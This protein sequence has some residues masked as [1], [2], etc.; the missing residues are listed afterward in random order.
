VA[1]LPFF[2]RG[3]FSAVVGAL[4]VAAAIAAERPP[5]PGT[6]RARLRDEDGALPNLLLITVDTLRADHVES[7]G[8]PFPGLTPSLDQ[9]AATGTVF[10]NTTSPAPAT[11]PGLAGLMTGSYAGRHHVLSNHRRVPVDVRVLAG[12]LKLHGYAT[13]AFVGNH[14]LRREQSGFGR[15]FEH[16][17]PFMPDEGHAS[18]GEGVRRAIAWLDG[19]PREPWLLWLHLMSP[20]GPYNSAPPPPPMVADREDP[21]PDRRLRLSPSNYG[22]GVLPKYQVLREPP[23]AA[24][25]RRRYRE[26]VFFVDAEIGHLLRALEERHLADRTL[27]I[28]ASDHGE[29]LGEH[30]LFFQHGWLPNEASVR[31]PMI[32]RLP[33]RVAEGHRVRAPVSLVD[34]L[35]TLVAGLGLP[36]VS[37]LAGR[38]LGAGLAGGEP[39]EAAVFI[40]TAYPNQMTAVRRGDWKLVHTPPPPDPLPGGGWRL[41][42]AKAEGWALYDLARD[43]GE[44]RDLSAAEPA[45]TAALRDELTRWEKENLLSRQ[46]REPPPVDAATEER[47]RALGYAD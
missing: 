31:V 24:D 19:S 30:E 14:V 46:L 8:S 5:T 34:V 38:D 35:P 11:R 15:G 47:L 12:V 40:V 41:F 10:V 32:W 45:R 16:Y 26:E 18:D 29:S 4:S 27:L 33:G 3:S 7:H 39:P 36:T 6:E 37:G 44:T 13:A 42:Y 17:E 1:L 2:R 22:L 25:Y 9:L 21:L 20:H 23:R 43:P 28:V